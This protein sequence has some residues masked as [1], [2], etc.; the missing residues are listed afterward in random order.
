MAQ[1]GQMDLARW[2]ETGKAE[3]GSILEIQVSY[4]L[5]KTILNFMF[6]ITFFLPYARLVLLVL[7]ELAPIKVVW[8]YGS[9][10]ASE[11]LDT[12]SWR[13]MKF[14]SVHFMKINLWKKI[15]LEKVCALNVSD[16]YLPLPVSWCWTLLDDD[17]GCSTCPSLKVHWKNGFPPQNAFVPIF[18]DLLCCPVSVPHIFGGNA[19]AFDEK[20]LLTVMLSCVVSLSMP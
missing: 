17:A 4:S 11:I 18:N 5:S 8:F 16:F 7:K 2:P 13:P 10:D 12:S 20:G 3:T 14:G 19:F 6:E 9:W 15:S 1:K